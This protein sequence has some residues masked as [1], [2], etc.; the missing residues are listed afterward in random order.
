MPNG[1]LDRRTLQNPLDA[2]I[3][4]TEYLPPTSPTEE[5]IAEIWSAFLK[6]EKVS[7]HSDFFELG[8]HSL[9]ATQIISKIREDY[10]I[11]LSLADFFD[12]PTVAD[13]ATQIDALN[14]N[15]ELK[16]APLKPFEGEAEEF[17][18]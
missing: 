2:V 5:K 14:W 17:E 1:K 12:G 9:L 10:A 15:T 6:I 3:D 8:G 13:L 4:T 16:T 11:G 18:F 7:V